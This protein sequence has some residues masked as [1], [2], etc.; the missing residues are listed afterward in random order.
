MATISAFHFLRPYWLLMLLPVFFLIIY[1]WRVNQIRHD[2][3]GVCDRHLLPALLVS[4]AKKRFRWELIL[5]A[6]S[7]MLAVVILAGPSWL[8]VSQPVYYS[9]YPRVLVLDLSPAMNAQDIVPSRLE[10]ARYKIL[11]ILQRQREGQFGLVAFSAEAYVVSPLTHDAATIEAMIAELKTEIMPVPGSNITAA[12]HQ[13]DELIKQAGYAKGDIILLTASSPSTT[14]FAVAKQLKQQGKRLMVLAMATAQGA[15]LPGQTGFVSDTKGQ[16]LVSKLDKTGL[17]TLAIEGDGRYATF[18]D[19]RQDIDLLLSND[20]ERMVEQ[21]GKEKQEQAILWQDN[22]G[23]LIFILLPV[24][25][26]A[27]RRGWFERI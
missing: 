23:L 12:L 16:L 6:L 21:S 24:A 7:W 13:A 18:S 8:K 2:W 11:D 5:L 22:G 4:G 19:T 26:L 25:L 14:D 17:E 1:L 27:F 3:S 9:E 15:P 10:R 20:D